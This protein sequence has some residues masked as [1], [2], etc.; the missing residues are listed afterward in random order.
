MKYF[1]LQ[2]TTIKANSSF[3]FIAQDPMNFFLRTENNPL[4]SKNVPF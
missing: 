3:L 2:V 1:P 4:V